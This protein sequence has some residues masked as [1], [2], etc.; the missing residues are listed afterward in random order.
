MEDTP[1]QTILAPKDIITESF[2]IKQ[3]KDNYK[4]N[5]NVFNQDIAL[6]LLEEKDLMKEYEKILSLNELKQMHTIFLGL[7][8]CKDFVD[9]IKALIENNKLSIKKNSENKITIELT[10]EYLFKQNI[11]KIDL[12]KKKINFELIAPQSPIPNPQSPI[13]NPQSPIP[14]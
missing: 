3:D 6:N 13:P 14:N 11:I 2:E 9:Y 4:L 5:I 1:L 7:N 8:S 12:N 10:V